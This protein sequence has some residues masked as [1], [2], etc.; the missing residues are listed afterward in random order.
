MAAAG[1]DEDAAVSARLLGEPYRFDFFQAVR[2]L[3]QL[4]RERAGAG[5]GRRRYPVGHDWA[6]A[7][8]MVRFR[9]LPGLSFPAAAVGQLRRPDGP[10]ANGSRPPEMLVTFMGL[11][12]PSGVLPQHYTTLLLQRLRLKDTSLRDFLDLLNHRLI[13]LFYRAWEKYRF[14]VAYERAKR[15]PGGAPDLFTHCLACLVG[16]G[17]ANLGGRLAVDDAALLLYGGFFAHFPRPAVCLERLLA[18]HFRVPVAAEQFAGQWLSLGADDSTCFP[19]ADCPEGRNTQL[20]IDALAGDRIWDVQSKL[21]LRVGRLTYE[22]FQRLLPTGA[23]WPAFLDLTRTYLG[24]DLDF[25]VQLVLAAPEV[26]ACRLP[27]E[28][29]PGFRLGWDTWVCTFDCMDDVDDVVL[30]ADNN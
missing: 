9:A 19:G 17:T 22:Q 23:D 24:P 10:A 4:E 18:D 1:G 16:M 13:S 8:E 21:R 20:G 7:Q 14:P 11:T 25:E 3:E 26:P 29:E 27:V 2:L 5:A 15:D 12:G 6:P 30:S 28:D